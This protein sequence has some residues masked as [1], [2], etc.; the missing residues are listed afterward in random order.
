MRADCELCD[1]VAGPGPEAVLANEA[2]AVHVLPGYEIDGWLAVVARRHVAGLGRLADEQA[3]SLGPTLRRVATAAETATGAGRSYLVALGEQWEH[4]HALVAPVPSGLPDGGRG[5][6]LL[7]N[8]RDL[9]DPAA[10]RATAQ[11]IRSILIDAQ[12][13][14]A[15]D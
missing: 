4:W 14:T 11:R 13:H 3:A 2:W 7:K 1:L 10:A 9:R 12:P 8:A 15:D 5:L 6:S